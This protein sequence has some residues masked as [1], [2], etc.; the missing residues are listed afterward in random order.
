MTN[1]QMVWM[2]KQN[3]GQSAISAMRAIYNA[4]YC[5]GAGVTPT[6]NMQDYSKAKAV[7][8]AIHKINSPD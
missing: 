6:A 1:D 8:V 7:P 5:E 2:Y 4:G 3:V